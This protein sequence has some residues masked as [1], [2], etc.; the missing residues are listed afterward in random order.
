MTST[1]SSSIL[2]QRTTSTTASPDRFMYVSGLSKSK[3]SFLNFVL[4]KYP[5]NWLD[6]L[7]LTP[8]SVPSKSTTIHPTLWRVRSYLEP[9]FPSPTISFIAANFLALSVRKFALILNYM[10]DYLR[11][12]FIND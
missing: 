9:G 1:F 12:L 7:R 5:L 6:V 3:S 11:T 4:Q 2:N 8:N 10:D